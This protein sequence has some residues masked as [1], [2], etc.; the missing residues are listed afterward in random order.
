MIHTHQF[1][2]GLVLLAE[3][4]NWLESAA[5]TILV[6]SGCVHEPPSRSGLSGF[7]CE[8][9]LR[10]AGPRDSRRFINDLDC[11][12][13]ERSE[14]VGEAHTRFGGAAQADNLPDALT[15]FADLLQRPHFPPDQLEA[16]R[17]VMFQELRAVEDEPA[18]KV[19]LQ[20]RQQH[21]PDPWGRPS[22]GDAEGIDATSIDDIRRFFQQA[23]HPTGTII[24]VAGRIDWPSLR[25]IVGG[26][27]EEWKPT[28]SLPLVESTPGPDYAHLPYDSNQTHIGI[29][30][31]SVPYRSEDYFPAWGP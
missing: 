29:A 16:G 27:F 24:G 15:I 3:P 2:N 20:L 7:T 21:Y 17:H 31:R 4:M 8:M 14:S 18:Q 11:L 6:P 1:A 30:Y 23:Y 9:A 12:G 25:D 5:F 13:V 22:Q 28:E 19:M 26:L 10:G